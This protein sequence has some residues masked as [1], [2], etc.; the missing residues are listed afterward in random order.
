MAEVTGVEGR[1]EAVIW[2]V[3]EAE[4]AGTVH[5]AA[6]MASF[7]ATAAEQAMEL[8]VGAMAGL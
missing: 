3:A 7:Q 6:P 5:V 4:W 8:A 1:A 2:G